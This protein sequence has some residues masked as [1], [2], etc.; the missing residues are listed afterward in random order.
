MRD[1]GSLCDT[2][3]LQ[4]LSQESGSARVYRPRK[5]QR[6][7]AIELVDKMMPLMS[8][9]HSQCSDDDVEELMS[10]AASRRAS[11]IVAT[12]IQTASRYECNPQPA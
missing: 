5:L 9:F 2:C 7:V 3:V 12:A 11:E 1:G 6:M 8:P 10:F 4:Q